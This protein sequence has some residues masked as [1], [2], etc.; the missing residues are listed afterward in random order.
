MDIGLID[1]INALGRLPQA[2]KERLCAAVAEGGYH[3]AEAVLPELSI[4]RPRQVHTLEKY[5]Y[6]E[7]SDT[8]YYIGDYNRTHHALFFDDNGK[9]EFNSRYYC[10][11]FANFL[12]LID[13]A[14]NLIET[15]DRTT[16]I[17]VGNDFVAIEKWFLSYGHFQDELFSVNDFM[18]RKGLLG[19]ARAFFDY[20]TDSHLDTPNFKF[21][22][23]YK[24][25]DKL[26]FGDS[27]LNAYNY[28]NGILKLHGLTL[29]DNHITSPTF[30]RFP[31]SVANKAREA[32]I[33]MGGET[34]PSKVFITRSTSYRDIGNKAE[35]EAFFADS[36]F[37]IVN[38]EEISI[39]ELIKVL[40]NAKYVGMY[41][42]SA[43]TNMI[44][45][46]KGTNVHVLQA[47]SYLHEGLDIWQ[48][49][50][51]EYNIALNVHRVSD[52]NIVDLEDL[53]KINF[54]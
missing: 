32:A 12:E 23:N 47:K 25:L 43:M 4:F 37:L 54:S 15:C 1:K 18:Q 19:K 35:I 51:T 46:P 48:N 6:T 13:Q 38:P 44:Y 3:R 24:L 7:N 9:I 17:D 42:G 22:T 10:T 28:G 31:S 11:H 20:P 50:L 2:D 40:A 16:A 41:F 39:I 8:F 5:R 52:E 49:I 53:K 27:S 34:G 30:H 33:A 21:N 45:M 29:I 26:V 14:L 36:G